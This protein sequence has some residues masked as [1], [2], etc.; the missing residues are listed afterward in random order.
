MGVLIFYAYLL[1]R[2]TRKPKWKK[3]KPKA[4]WI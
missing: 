1:S 4:N 3:V 2:L